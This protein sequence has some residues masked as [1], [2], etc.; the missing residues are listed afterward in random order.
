MCVSFQIKPHVVW[1]EGISRE[2]LRNVYFVVVAKEYKISVFD[3][4]TL[5]WYV[6][7]Y[8]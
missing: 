4:D 5:Q 2:A 7:F 8:W 1:N 6:C 3:D